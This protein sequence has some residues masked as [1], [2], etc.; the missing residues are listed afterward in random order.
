MKDGIRM[1]NIRRS[2]RRGIG[3]PEE[4]ENREETLFK[5]I[6]SLFNTIQ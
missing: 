5:E 2:H 3:I 4:I 6:I 1:A